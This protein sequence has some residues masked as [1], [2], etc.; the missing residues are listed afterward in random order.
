MMRVGVTNT[1]TGTGTASRAA[2]L[3]RPCWGCCLFAGRASVRQALVTRKQ[4][5]RHGSLQPNSAFVM[6]VESDIREGS[7]GILP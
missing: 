6:L 2:A 5:T 7:H 1:A 4:R 3:S